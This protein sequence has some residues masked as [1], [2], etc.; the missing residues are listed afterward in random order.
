MPKIPANFSGLILKLCV[1]HQLP[2]F[3]NLKIAL[4]LDKLNIL[5][6]QVFTDILIT[7]A[8][9]FRLYDFFSHYFGFITLLT[10]VLTLCYQSLLIFISTV[11][12][13]IIGHGWLNKFQENLS[14]FKRNGSE[15]FI[16][17]LHLKIDIF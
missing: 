7:Y 10:I 5:T 2:K 3:E 9:C 12:S 13:H 11:D 15:K 14:S 16:N 6:T 4:N 17:K 1:L 8:F